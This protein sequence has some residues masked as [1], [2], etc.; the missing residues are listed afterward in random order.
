[1]KEF[2]IREKYDLY[3]AMEEIMEVWK[4]SKLKKKSFV[5]WPGL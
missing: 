4:V 2:I 3:D 1:M 5:G